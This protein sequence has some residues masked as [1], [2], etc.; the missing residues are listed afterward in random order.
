MANAAAEMQRILREKSFAEF[1]AGIGLVRAGLETQGW[2]VS[3]A[4]DIDPRKFEMYQGHFGKSKEHFVLGDIHDL[5][6]AT[7]PTVTLA[8]ASFPCKDLSL[9]GARKGL[10]GTHSSAFWGFVRLLEQLGRKKP[11]LVMLENVMGFLSA[12]QGRD[13]EQALLALNQ[14]GYRVD[15]F[16]IDAADFAPQSRMRLFV[17]GSLE[18]IF[19][20]QDT[21]NAFEELPSYTRPKALSSFILKHQ[22][23]RWNI[24]SLPF[25]PQSTQTLADIIEELPENSS[26]WWSAER[27]EYLLNQMSPRHRTIANGMIVGDHWSYGTVFRRM[28]NG[29]STAEL[30]TDGLAGCLRTPAGGSAKQ[31]VF[32]A[33]YGKYFARLL[34]PTECARLMG[35]GQYNIAVPFDQAFL[36]FGDAVCVPVVEWIAEHYL[37]AIINEY[38]GQV[39]PEPMLAGD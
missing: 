30:R 10:G 2:S 33:G 17:I 39:L 6:V 5:Q 19:P 23:I 28:R 13:F 26:I 8:T 7:L 36:G 16:T 37:N 12:N 21:D 38:I 15:A 29:Q 14:S 18:N 20:V 25:P 32:K 3:F 35:I 31:I 4:N 1:F 27:A 22:H 24:R 34:I 9:A 11:P